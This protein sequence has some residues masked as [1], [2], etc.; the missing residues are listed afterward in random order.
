[1]FAFAVPF[2][3]RVEFKVDV[4]ALAEFCLLIFPSEDFQPL[5]ESTVAEFAVS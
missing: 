1:M 3:T 4:L 2:N 5:V